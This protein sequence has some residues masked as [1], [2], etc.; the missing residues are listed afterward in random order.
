MLNKKIS[1]YVPSTFDVDKT[2][3]NSKQV[4]KVLKAFSEMFGG[5]TSTEAVG[6]W[7]DQRGRVIKEQ[8]TIVY[9]FTDVTGIEK[10]AIERLKSELNLEQSQIYYYKDLAMSKFRKAYY[11]V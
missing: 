11:G 1:I 7:V 5:A 3:D 4:D 2:A 8:V 9:A 10:D 6:A